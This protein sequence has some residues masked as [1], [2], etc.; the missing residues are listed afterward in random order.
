MTRFTHCDQSSTSELSAELLSPWDSPRA[1]TRLC[2]K[3]VL[4]SALGTYR[5]SG[6]VWAWGAQAQRV[7][8]EAEQ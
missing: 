4:G 3:D 7:S 6:S 8:Q 1:S 2:V 5:P